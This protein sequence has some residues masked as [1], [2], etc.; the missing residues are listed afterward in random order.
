VTSFFYSNTVKFH[1]SDHLILRQG[2]LLS[3]PLFNLLISMLMGLHDKNDLLFMGLER[4]LAVPA[5]TLV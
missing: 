5:N 3:L 2:P 4:N 1:Y